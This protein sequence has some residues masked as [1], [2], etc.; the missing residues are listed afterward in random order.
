MSTAK[1]ALAMNWWLPFVRGILLVLFGVIMLVMGRGVTLIAAIQL[2]GAYWLAGG[3]LDLFESVLGQSEG[4]R[5][6]MAVSA[7]VSIVAG[8]VVLSYPVISGI[9]ASTYLTLFMGISAVVAGAAHLFSRSGNK[10]S[11]PGIILGLFYIIFGAAVIFNPLIT[12]A[13]IVLLL[14]FWALLAGGS[15]IAVGVKIRI[16]GG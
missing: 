2:L 9:L 15:A 11:L 7:L 12:Q 5:V 16:Q 6:R 14:P 1:T 13:V 10:R 4:S 3:V 8:F